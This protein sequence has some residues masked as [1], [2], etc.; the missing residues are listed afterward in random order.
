MSLSTLMQLRQQRVGLVALI[1]NASQTTIALISISQQL[2]LWTR[3]NKTTKGKSRFTMALSFLIQ[4]VRLE[5]VTR[6]SPKSPLPPLPPCREEIKRP[7]KNLLWFSF[8]FKLCC[9]FSVLC[10]C[11]LI[12]ALSYIFP[13]LVRFYYVTTVCNVFDKF[14]F[15]KSN[16]SVSES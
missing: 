6:A 3:G 4:I 8:F 2:E 1:G 5:K 16:F 14:I 11:W 7:H 10:C 12:A 13:F 9:H 15:I